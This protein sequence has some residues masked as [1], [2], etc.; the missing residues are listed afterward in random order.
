MP[1]AGSRHLKAIY[2]TYAEQPLFHHWLEYADQYQHHLPKPEHISKPKL[3]LLEMGVSHGGST[4]VW[5]QYYGQKLIYV[6]LE[7]NPE[8]K[9]SERVEEDI[10]VE[11]GSQTNVTF[12]KAIC[13]KYGPFDVIVDDAAHTYHAIQESLLYLFPRCLVD[14][15]VYAIEDLHTMSMPDYKSTGITSIFR[16]VVVAMHK[17]WGSAKP[18]GYNQKYDALSGIVLNL[19]IYD[20]LAFLLKGK[21]KPL[22]EIKRSGG[23]DVLYEKLRIGV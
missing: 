11:T 22:T 4:R 2:E 9:R 6:G 13:A 1:Q 8:S 20:S 5:K 21:A 17:Y 15:G 7:I 23:K 10:Y 12:L 14:G 18:R 3:R 19:H 16:N